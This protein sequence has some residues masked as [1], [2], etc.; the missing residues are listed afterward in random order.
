MAKLLGR[1]VRRMV[2][3]FLA[4]IEFDF[5]IPIPAHAR[6]LFFRGYNQ[7]LLMAMGFEEKKLFSQTL[8]KHKHTPSQVGLPREQRLKNIKNSFEVPQKYRSF[9]KN[10]RL[11]L[12]DDVITTGAT[13][14]E[15]AKVLKKAGASKIY[16]LA[17]AKSTL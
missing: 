3:P 1:L 9:L 5:I 17:I 2:A 7:A 8:K 16:A 6:R 10:R 15:A 12:F 4:K 11:L 13:L 14:N